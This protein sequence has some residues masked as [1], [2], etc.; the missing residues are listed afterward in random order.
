MKAIKKIKTIILLWAIVTGISNIA[1]G[2]NQYGIQGTIYSQATK[3]P[4]EFATIA[5][6]E[7]KKKFYTKADGTYSIQVENPGT[8]TLIIS[9]SGFQT[10]T[11][12]VTIN[13]VIQKDIVLKPLAI[14]GAAL[15]ITGERDIQKVSR[16]TLTV[17]D[18]KAVPASFGDSLNALTSLP[19][20]IRTGGFFGPLVIR[21]ADPSFNGYFIDDIPVYNPQHFG[22]IHSI[23]NNDLMNEIDLYSSSFPSPYANAIGAVI[24][25]NTIDTVKE[26]GGSADVGLISSN[27]LLKSPIIEHSD[28]TNEEQKKGYWIVSGR[29]AYLSLFVPAVYKLLTGDEIESVPE[30]WDYQFKGKYYFSKSQSITF[31]FFGAYDY[32]KFINESTPPEEVDPL[33]ASFEFKNNLGSHAVGIYYRWQ[34]V[35]RF[36]NTIV[37]FGSL[38]NSYNYLNIPS[39]SAADWVKDLQITSKPYIYGAKEKIKLEWWKDHAQ[40]RGALEYTLYHFTNDGYTLV[41]NAPLYNIPDFGD[42]DL[43]TKVPLGQKFNNHVIGAYAEQKFMFG[44]LTIL[45]G[46]RTDYLTCTKQQTVDPRFMASYEFP[47]QTTLSYATGKYSGFIQTNSNLFN[48]QPNLAGAGDEYKPQKAYHNAISIE[49]KLSLLTIKAEGFYNYF[50]DLYQDDPVKDINDNVI[51]E[52]KSCGKLKT[53]GFEL[54]IRIDQEENAD[55]LFG[56]INYTYTKAEFKTGASIDPNGDKW[57]P[58]SYEQPHSLKMVIGYTIGKHTLSARFQAYSGFP[59]TPVIGS[60]ESPDGSGRYVPIYDYAHLHSKRF[61]WEH[62]LDVRYSNKT[63]HEWGYV[64]WYIE[65]INI[66]NYKPKNNL[67]WN[68]YKE[69]GDDNPKLKSEEGLSFIPNFGVEV[70]F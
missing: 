69:K 37:V 53:R 51:Q 27:I 47:T 30:Y 40:F 29:Y 22:A 24:S 7:I 46:I 70:K 34:P 50:E 21:G 16:Y 48:F 9:S 39:D 13:G 36:E 15:T 38:T 43:F 12:S 55:G 45:P 65:V 58:S 64:S 4:V 57:F 8:Y 68:Y 1:T 17:K 20:V 19:G 54:Q 66:Y 11:F 23:I 60:D 42:P 63:N 56:W 49:Q 31:L 33:L 2:Q 41:A 35:S 18:L 14:K 62:R 10:L 44:G 32:I 25:I 61:P 67:A 6:A 3:K 5:I 52:G 26:F 59:Y 28:E